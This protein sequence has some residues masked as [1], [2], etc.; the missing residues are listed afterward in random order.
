[1]KKLLTYILIA[2][3]SSVYAYTE[4]D[5]EIYNGCKDRVKYSLASKFMSNSN[6]DYE[7]CKEMLDHKSALKKYGAESSYNYWL[8]RLGKK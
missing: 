1:M 5:W 8:K 2:S 4:K 3:I 7:A 6:L